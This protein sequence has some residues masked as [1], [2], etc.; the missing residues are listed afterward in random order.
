LPKKI[1]NTYFGH[2]YEHPITKVKHIIPSN[3]FQ[4]Y[5]TLGETYLVDQHS[6]FVDSRLRWIRDNVTRFI[7]K[8]DSVQRLTTFQQMKNNVLRQE[9]KSNVKNKRT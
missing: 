1:N 4:F 8:N 6:R 7:P 9:K 3:R 2:E 5:S